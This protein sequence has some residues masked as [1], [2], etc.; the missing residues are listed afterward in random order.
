MIIVIGSIYSSDCHNSVITVFILF[1]TKF[2]PM[3]IIYE[4]K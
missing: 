1:K 2:L 4:N 3:A